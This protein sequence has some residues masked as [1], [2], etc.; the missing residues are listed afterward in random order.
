MKRL[1]PILI[2]MLTL[3]L[4]ACG[5]D[6]DADAPTRE[7]FADRASEICREAERLAEDIGEQAQTRQEVADAVDQVIQESRDA[8]DR[9]DELELPEG[10]AGETAE[11]FVNETRNDIVDEGIPILEDLRDAVEENDAQAAQEA[12]QRLDAIDTEGSDRAA[13]A[14]GADACAD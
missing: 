11:R 6:D 14:L 13:R 3:G 10:E 7:E 9:L 8:V 2:C 12:S 1:A 4:A 5:D